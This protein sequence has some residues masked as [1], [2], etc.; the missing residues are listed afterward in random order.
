MDGGDITP[1]AHHNDG[2]GPSNVRM[3]THE[4]LSKIRVTTC[5]LCLIVDPPYPWKEDLL[6]RQGDVY[7]LPPNAHRDFPID[8]L[9]SDET[10]T[11]SAWAVNEDGE[12]ISPVATLKVRPKDTNRGD[13]KGAGGLWNPGGF[14][15]YL[16]DPAKLKAGQRFPAVDITGLTTTEF[17]VLK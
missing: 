5:G 4:Y 9:A 17:T 12:V 13:V 7:A 8:T 11:I 16:T 3:P 10:Y 6:P 15:D 14:A 1:A 2:V